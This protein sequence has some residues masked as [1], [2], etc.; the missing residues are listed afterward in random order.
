MKKNGI[1]FFSG[2]KDGLYA[3]YLAQNRGIDVKYL[4]TL[5]TT[6]GLSPHY[7]NLSALKK[8]AK[9]MGKEML[10]F[11]MK[12]GEKSLAK[13]I[14][15]LGVDYLIGGD[16]FL[17]EHYEYIKKLADEIGIS[18]LEPL[19]D[20]SSLEL[21]DKIIEDEFKYAIIAV[22]KEKLSKKYLGY[23]FENKENLKNFVEKNPEVDPMGEYGEF[24]TV[25]TSSPLFSNEF[26]F[27]P[28]KYEE[29]EIYHYLK[30]E[31]RKNEK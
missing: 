8:I 22:N 20:I 30:F 1:A 15:N 25:V 9:S 10:I 23:K 13:F 4:L 26:E 21:A 7:E 12:K 18:M 19:W 5:K 14:S 6:I 29:S 16:I 2:G 24:H 31:V 27:I 28:M 3:V 11:D 17:N